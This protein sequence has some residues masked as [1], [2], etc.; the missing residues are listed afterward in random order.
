MKTKKY[1]LDKDILQEVY[2]VLKSCSIKAKFIKAHIVTESPLDS[3][4]YDLLSLYYN[5]I[6]NYMHEI[7]KLILQEGKYYL[8]TQE[9]MDKLNNYKK[10]I[11]GIEEEINSSPKYSLRIH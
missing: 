9:L 10:I 1:K 4:Y 6:F 2:T 7:E 5:S 8:I 11:T 3:Y